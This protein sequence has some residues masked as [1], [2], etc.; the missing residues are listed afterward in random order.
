VVRLAQQDRNTHWIVFADPGLLSRSAKR[1]GLPLVIERDLM[2]PARSAGRVTVDAVPLP[3]VETP[4]RLDT[5]NAGYVLETLTRAADACLAGRCAGVVTGPVQKS[6]IN[7]A[8]IRFSG[9]TEFFCERAGVEDVV[10][11]L[12][13][14]S[15]RVA[16]AT[17]HLPLAAV[18]AAITPDLLRRRLTILL[19]GLERQFSIR[20]LAILVAGLNPHAGEGG[21]LGRE[22]IEVIAPV[23]EEFRQRGVSGPLPADSLFTPEQLTRADAAFVMYHDQGLPVLK[24]H[25]FGR[26]VNVTLGLPFIRTSV[27]HGTALDIAGSGEADP[28][29]MAEALRLAEVLAEALIDLRIAGAPAE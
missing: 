28:G 6:V 9:H 7:D 21:H 1:L 17:T 11:L 13:A 22:E 8:G 27:D 18:P 25:G 24:H 16:L 10:M 4:G 29:S 20:S 5:A 26:A 15:M 23:C 12:V 14:G 19:D 3:N 2:A